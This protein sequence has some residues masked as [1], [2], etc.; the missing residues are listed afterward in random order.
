MLLATNNIFPRL[1]VPHVLLWERHSHQEGSMS[2]HCPCPKSRSIYRRRE[3]RQMG[4]RFA[5]LFRS[6]EHGKQLERKAKMLLSPK[7]R[8]VVIKL[9]GEED[10]GEMRRAV[11]FF[12][13]TFCLCSP[14]RAKCNLEIPHNERERCTYISRCL[15]DFSEGSGWKRVWNRDNCKC[16]PML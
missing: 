2:Y 16:S 4:R 3:E 6:R 13:E 8:A 11:L 7:L 12:S 1:A 5:G 15:S 9:A 14:L 10:Y